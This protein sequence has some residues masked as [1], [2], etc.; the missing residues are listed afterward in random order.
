MATIQTNVTL[1]GCTVV[2]GIPPTY[3]S[4]DI[5]NLIAI[6]DAGMEFKQGFNRPTLLY[7]DDGWSENKY[8]DVTPDGSQATL[9]LDL[10]TVNIDS[11]LYFTITAYAKQ[12]VHLVDLSELTG[13]S[14]TPPIPPYYEEGNIIDISLYADEGTQFD[15]APYLFYLN[16]N[17]SPQTINFTLN[18]SKTLAR[19]VLEWGEL[20]TV[21]DS[22]MIYGSTILRSGGLPVDESNLTGCSITPPLP[23]VVYSDSVIDVTFVA[24]VDT[25]FETAP[26]VVFDN[27]SGGVNHVESILNEDGLT[28]TLY[29][30]MENYSIPSV[31]GQYDKFMV[32]GNTVP[33]EV[34]STNYGAINVY[35]VTLDDLDTFSKLRIPDGV[36][37]G[38]YKDLSQYVN[39][40]KRIYTDIPT[41][42]QTSLMVGDV[43]T[44]IQVGNPSLVEIIL[45]FGNVLIPYINGNS[46]D[47]LSDIQVMLP[48]KGFVQLSSDYV[49][50]MINIEYVINVITGGGIAKF[51]HNGVVFQTEE[52][53][54]NSDVLYRGY[55]PND[56]LGDSNWDERYMYGFEPYIHLKFYESK[57]N[58]TPN[59]DNEVGKISNYRGMVRMENVDSIYNSQMFNRER[60][61]I[62]RL[63]ESG[64]RIE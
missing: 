64:I 43:N 7:Y 63:I 3:E 44:G 56:L 62:Y 50:E 40:I 53:Q 22:L 17:Y 2:G 18:P 49:G 39:R 57:N 9:T 37:P 31:V 52:I 51:Y 21:E 23:T 5:I 14:A 26:Y 58:T 60:E 46:V 35:K 34:I 11:D 32:Y 33:S 61:E 48:F 24:D 1:F 54:P 38:E 13:C 16:E 42:I 30:D 4:I 29:L 12:G 59:N 28:A 41:N 25:K 27:D 36:T 6:P 45:N 47:L 55:T 19:L 8:F 20:G 10:S 15:T